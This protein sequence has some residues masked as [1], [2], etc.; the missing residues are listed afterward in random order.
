MNLRIYVDFSGSADAMEFLRANAGGHEL[1]FP[2]KPAVSVL[3][4]G[5]P[6]RTFGEADVAFGQPDTEAIA[7]IERWIN[8]ELKRPQEANN[9]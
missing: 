5:E 2:P 6:D 7:L 1:I 3:A 9:E 4:K 8:E